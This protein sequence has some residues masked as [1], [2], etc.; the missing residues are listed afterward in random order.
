MVA[1]PPSAHRKVTSVSQYDTNPHCYSHVTEGKGIMIFSK[2]LVFSFTTVIA[3][4]VN[5]S[6]APADCSD[7]LLYLKH[8]QVNNVN[9]PHFAFTL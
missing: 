3:Y 9:F 1:I 8:R 7:T 4:K 5:D 6:Y 2:F